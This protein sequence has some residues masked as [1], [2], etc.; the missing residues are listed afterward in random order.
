MCCVNFYFIR[1]L[2][3]KQAGATSFKMQN[4][5]YEPSQIKSVFEA[6]KSHQIQIK[7]STPEQRIAKLRALGHA[8]R[9]RSSEIHTALKLDLHKSSA[10]TNLTEIF[11]TL[12]EIEHTIRHL[13]KWIRPTRVKTPLSLFGTRSEIRYEPK[14]TILIIGPWNY[15]FSLMIIPL[16]SAIAAGNTAILKP[17]E[18]SKHTSSLLVSLISS[19]FDGKEVACIEGDASLSQTLLSLPFD[20]IF[21]TGST[22]VGQVVM[23]AAAKHLTPVTLELG[24]KSPVIIED[25]AHLPT[26]AQRIIWGKFVNARQTCVAPDYVFI[27]ENRLA[28]FVDEAKKAILKY[29]GV[30]ESERKDSGDY[31]RIISDGNF[32][33]I[34]RLTQESIAQGAQ[35]ETGGVFDEKQKYIAPTLLA[36]AK[37]DQPIMREEI[38]GPILPVMTYRSLEEVYS[39]LSKK[40]KPLALYIF[41]QNK[42]KIEEILKNTTAGGTSI[43]N[44]LIHLLNPYLPFGGV[45]SSGMGNYHGFFGFKTFSH[46]RAITRQGALNAL[47]FMYPPY[48][49]FV[50]KLIKLTIGH[51]T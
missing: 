5:S 34:Q 16:A 33:R 37:P 12:G 1:P 19:L 8:I 7:L 43:N 15:P 6:Q 9:T 30:K 36:G 47:K 50:K 22:R 28:P 26:A 3:L 27:P 18:I 14:G 42:S 48:T 24:G 35:A 11:T 4:K 40:E 23:E 32:H 46:E 41:S 31:C 51:L 20:H 39:F 10:E 38:F 2:P 44:T 49:S 17:S 21:F 13:R 45:G 29:Y 25:S